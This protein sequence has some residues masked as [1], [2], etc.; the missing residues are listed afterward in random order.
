MRKMLDKSFKGLFPFKIGTTS[1][2]YPD[3]ILPNVKALSPYLDEI[4]IV[5]FESEGQDNLPSNDEI[6]QL[7]SL[8]QGVGV[9][10]NVHLPIDVLL[11]HEDPVVRQRGVGSIQRIIALTQQLKPSNYTLHFELTEADRENNGTLSRWK[12]SLRLSMG[13]ILYSGVASSRIAVETLHYPF[14][15]VEDIVGE[16]GLSVCL[17]LGHMISQGYSIA[18]YAKR[19]LTKTPLIHLHGTKNGKDH[20]SVKVLGNDEMRTICGVLKDFSGIVSIEVFSFYDLSTSLKLLET[21]CQ[22]E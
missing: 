19:Y 14:E 20:V 18:E 12:E 8:A 11:G 4:E 9:T 22:G 5:L 7:C 3:H 1:Y 6:E 13:E 21:R 15:F 16:F 17:D 10:Y 2:I